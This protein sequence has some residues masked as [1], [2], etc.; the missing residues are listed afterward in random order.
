VLVDASVCDCCQLSFVPSPGGGALLA[1]RG[2]TQDEVRDMQLARFDGKTWSQPTGLNA[3]S[4]KIAGCPVNGPQLA[5]SGEQVGAV[6]FTSPDR[7]AQVLARTSTDSGATFGPVTRLD[8][9]RPLGRVDSVLLAGDTLAAV[10]LEA[11]GNEAG[12]TGGL[13]LRTLSASGRLSEPQLLAPS[14]ASR[15]VGFPRM[16]RAGAQRLLLTYTQEGEPTHV[17]T[18]QVDLN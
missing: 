18:V 5:A 8:I 14:S 10:W 12:G 11:S 13:Y 9:G 4:W 7:Q 2:R 17:R 1:Y 3:D 15:T 6:W 16:V